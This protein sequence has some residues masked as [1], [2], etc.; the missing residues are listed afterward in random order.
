MRA[1]VIVRALVSARARAG[2]RAGKLA[3]VR[4]LVC[5]CTNRRRV[6]K[7]RKVCVGLK[8]ALMDGADGVKEME[9]EE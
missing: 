5:A 7:K 1:R 2:V 9:M 3:G 6:Q 4:T 8:S